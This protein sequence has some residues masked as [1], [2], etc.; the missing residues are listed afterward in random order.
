MGR[1]VSVLDILSGRRRSLYQGELGRCRRRYDSRRLLPSPGFALVRRTSL[2]RPRRAPKGAPCECACFTLGLESDLVA[3]LGAEVPVPCGSPRSP[4]RS[5]QGRQSWV[6]APRCRAAPPSR[7]AAVPALGDPSR[8]D[9]RVPRRTCAGSRRARMTKPD[10]CRDRARRAD[11]LQRRRRELAGPP[12]R[13][14]AQRAL[15]RLAPTRARARLRGGR[16]RRRLQHER[17]GH[18]GAR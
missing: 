14:A 4:A 11:A 13:C 15:A 5:R 9:D 3:A 18:V 10:P 12:S 1:R 6:S 7:T 17:R 2:S 8:D 16:R